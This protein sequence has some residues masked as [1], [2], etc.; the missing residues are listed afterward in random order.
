MKNRI[1]RFTFGFVLF[2]A[3]TSASAQTDV[4]SL[5]DSPQQDYTFYSFGVTATNTTTW[6]T[7]FFR[8][9]PAYWGFDDVALTDTNGN[10]LIVNGGFETGD[11][12]GWMLVGQ[13]GLPAAGV[14]TSGSGNPGPTTWDPHSG[15]YFWRDGAV[16]GVDGIAQGIPTDVGQDYTLSFWL[17]GDGEASGDINSGDYA[18]FDAFIGA[19]VST[20]NG[21]QI[22][23]NGEPP[24][25]GGPVTTPEPSTLALAGLGGLGLLLF[26]RH[27]SPR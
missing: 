25:D 7:V 4:L 26:R 15:S 23:Y 11:T 18:S 17:A 6:L 13:Q 16:G 1:L 8:Q 2:G 9:D 5:Q 22:L 21:I 27:Q 20:Y 19:Q 14:V 10:N 12:T 24:T 3:V